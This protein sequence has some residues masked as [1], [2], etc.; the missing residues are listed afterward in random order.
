[1]PLKLIHIC[2]LIVM[3]LFCTTGTVLSQAR[4]R[5]SL[6]WVEVEKQVERVTKSDY[7][8]GSGVGYIVFKVKK[9]NVKIL[10]INYSNIELYKRLHSLDGV[11]LNNR[12]NGNSKTIYYVSVSYLSE[13]SKSGK[14]F[15]NNNE[16]Y[17]GL[18][19]FQWGKFWKNVTVLKPVSIYTNSGHQ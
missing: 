17:E 10:E 8:I 4:E 9:N 3:F 5:D 14:V 15:W 13:D 1:M 11:A 12:R 16:S 18:H 2:S 6:L 7:R 19:N